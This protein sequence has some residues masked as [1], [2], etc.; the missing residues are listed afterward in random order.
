MRFLY[1]LAEK[2]R[3][4]DKFTMSAI[5]TKADIAGRDE[6]VPKC[7]KWTFAPRVLSPS[8]AVKAKIEAQ[9][10]GQQGHSLVRA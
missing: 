4:P 5:P 6:D 1:E 7:H 2:E 8:C 3:L 10:T 9:R